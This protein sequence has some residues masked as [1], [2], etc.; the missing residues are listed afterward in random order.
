MT[1]FLHPPILRTAGKLIE[2]IISTTTANIIAV[3]ISILAAKLY[4]YEGAHD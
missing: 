1:Y 2:E 4:S 3:A